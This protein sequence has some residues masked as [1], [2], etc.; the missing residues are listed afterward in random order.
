[1]YHR[2][3]PDEGFRHVI[4]LDGRLHPCRHAERL[5]FALQR[6]AVHYRRQHPH[7]IRRCPVHAPLA[8]RLSP[9][10]IAAAHHQR[11]LDAQRMDFP[12]LLR[13]AV[14]DL[15]RNVVAAARLA[16]RLSAELQDDALVFRARLGLG[17]QAEMKLNGPGDGKGK[18]RETRSA[19]AQ[20]QGSNLQGGVL[21]QGLAE[22]APQLATQGREWPGDVEEIAAAWPCL[23]EA[24]RQ[25]VLVIVRS[26]ADW[27][28][29]RRAESGVPPKPPGLRG[30]DGNVWQSDKD[31]DLM[32]RGNLPWEGCS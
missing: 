2:P 3:P 4:H 10:D 14:D 13:D 6:Q 27:Q 17:H 26:T 9:P 29:K 24:M 28:A 21:H 19:G 8:G 22:E 30:G 25:A 1:V 12:D 20:M 15:R 18:R 5:Q 31:C 11:D 16:Q 23:G 32:L 7:V